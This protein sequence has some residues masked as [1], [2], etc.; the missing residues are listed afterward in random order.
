MNVYSCCYQGNLGYC[1]RRFNSTWMFVPELGQPDNRVHKNV[2]FE[3]L[4]FQN[5]NARNYELESEL[6]LAG[7]NFIEP[8][9]KSLTRKSRP[10]TMGGLLFCA[11]GM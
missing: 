1:C 8:I 4:I 7:I 10:Q 11:E 5:L 2:P 3:D 6:R 9:R